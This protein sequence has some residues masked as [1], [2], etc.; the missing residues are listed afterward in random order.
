MRIGYTPI[1]DPHSGGGGGYALMLYSY[2]LFLLH[3]AQTTGGFEQAES[4][5][6]SRRLLKPSSTTCAPREAVQES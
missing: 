4:V 5:E 6:Q 3:H 2:C 1:T